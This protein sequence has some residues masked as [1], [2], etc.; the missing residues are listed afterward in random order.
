MHDEI[1]N[2]HLLFTIAQVENTWETK[3]LMAGNGLASRAS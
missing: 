2:Y 1:K 3:Q